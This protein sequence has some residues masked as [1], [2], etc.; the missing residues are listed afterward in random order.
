MGEAC[1][2]WEYRS[3]YEHDRD[4]LWETELQCLTSDGIRMWSRSGEIIERAVSLERRAS[5]PEYVRPPNEVFDWNFWAD[6]AADSETTAQK[7]PRYEV[8]LRSA[9][10]HETQT[11][12]RD[13][14]WIYSETLF[15]DR[16]RSVFIHN[17]GTLNLTYWEIAGNHPDSLLI[18][19]T[20]DIPSR[21]L[22]LI[23]M[24]SLSERVLDE[25]CDWFEK[26]GIGIIP[27]RECRTVD[28][29]LLQTTYR[30]RTGIDV[31]LTATAINRRPLFVSLAPPALAFR[32]GQCS[33]TSILWRLTEDRH[34]N[35]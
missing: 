30:S 16:R 17:G 15:A 33:G 11:I 13:S 8:R 10:T 32:F 9:A 20:P 7:G 31:Q 18:M 34:A 24:A 6:M 21:L 23:R 19:F 27:I 5:T 28:D 22:P 29:I 25:S 2:V 14:S 35:C 4:H 12:R 3:G 1:E 26:P